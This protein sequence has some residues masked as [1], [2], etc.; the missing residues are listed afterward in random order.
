MLI[1]MEGQVKFYSPQNTAKVLQEKGIAVISQTVVVNGDQVL[2]VKKKYTI[3]PLIASI[4][5]V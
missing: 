1:L 3:D 2:N 5:F 4:R